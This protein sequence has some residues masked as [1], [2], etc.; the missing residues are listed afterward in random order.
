M[1]RRTR[2]PPPLPI[3]PPLPPNPRPTISRL[4]TPIIN[5]NQTIRVTILATIPTATLEVEIPA[6]I[7]TA[8]RATTRIPATITTATTTIPRT[9]TIATTTTTSMT[10]TAS[11]CFTPLTRPLHFRN[12]LNRKSQA[13]AIYGPPATGVGLQTVTTG[14]QARGRVHPNLVI[15]GPPDGGDIAAA[16]IATTTAIGAGTLATTA[17]SITET[18][19]PAPVIRAAT[20]MEIA[21]TTTVPSTMSVTETSRSTIAPLQTRPST[22]PPLTTRPSTMS[23]TTDPAASRA[24]PLPQ[25]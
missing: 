6:I 16:A 3:W 10:P 23:V 19:T 14:S 7:P 20:G 1:P 8:T 13:M 9:T 12:I 4:R 24:R 15:C 11:R 25:S 18:A 2:I 22:T 5:S 17:A 21:S